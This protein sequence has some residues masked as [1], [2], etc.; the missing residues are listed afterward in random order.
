VLSQGVRLNS[1]KE[2]LIIFTRYPIV[3]AT[4]TRLIPALGEEGAT[5]LH[6]KMT[7]FTLVQAQK[8]GASIDVRYTG[9]SQ[10]EMR[11][12]LGNEFHYTE[13]GEGSLGERMERAFSDHF[14]AGAERV[15]VIGCDCP[16]NRS[17]TIRSAFAKLE[18]F[19]AVIGPAKDGGYYLLGL[20][21]PVPELFRLSQWGTDAV[22][23]ETLA[24]ANSTGLYIET[25]PLLGDV[26]Y[27]E[28]IPPLISVVIPTFNEAKNIA[29]TIVPLLDS[30]N[31]EIIV[32]DGGSSDATREIAEK[33][34]VRVVSSASGRAVQMNVGARCS[35]GEILLFLHADTTLPANW[36]TIIRETISSADTAVGA[37]RFRVRERLFGISL[38]EWGTNIRAKWFQRPYGDQALFLK[39]NLFK[40]LGNYPELPILEDLAL[41][42]MA[43]KYGKITIV[44]QWAE[45]SGRRWQR[46]GV[47][48]TTLQNQVILLGAF[49]G[50]SLFTLTDYYR[51][52]KSKMQ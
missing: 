13:Q 39:R 52:K 9:G 17:A 49:L 11:N 43:Q 5:E 7:E 34:G 10:E 50:V 42:K 8:S 6:R 35:R 51:G 22:F 33:F 48:G 45:T 32:S 25:L 31:T 21:R 12:W 19:P 4:K 3:G 30:F 23:Q 24:V 36:D 16:T 1:S 18:K 27:V 47:L 40:E 37:F 2:I 38:V 26:D 44:S 15:V 28:D 14:S 20:T 46:Y 29:D 41:V